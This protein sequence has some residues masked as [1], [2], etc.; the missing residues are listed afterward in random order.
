MTETTPTAQAQAWLTQFGQALARRDIEDAVSMFGD[1]CY[2]RDLVSFT[3]N[4]CT[5][6]SREQVHAMLTARLDDVAPSNWTLEGE[7]TEADGVTE[8]WVTFETRVARGKGLLRLRDG[9][10]QRR[11]RIGCRSLRLNLR[12]RCRQRICGG[13]ILLLRLNCRNRNLR[14]V[15][16]LLRSEG[17]V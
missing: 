12:E 5:Q 2:W 1:E 10:A 15:T 11:L 4:L 14:C 13:G 9:R 7:A 17:I 8:A 6:E 3:W 16:A